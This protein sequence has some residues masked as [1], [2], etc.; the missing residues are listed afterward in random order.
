M[1]LNV[2]DGRIYKAAKDIICFK[3]FKVDEVSGELISPIVPMVYELEKTYRRMFFSGNSV[4]HYPRCFR[5]WL[6]SSVRSVERGF[7]S[8][9][10]LETAQ[11]QSQWFY[12]V[13][14]CQIPK[15]TRYILGNG[16]EYVSLKIKPLEIVRHPKKE[17]NE[18]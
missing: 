9:R 7:H 16:D 15:G 17:W 14:R 12:A 11:R 18:Q 3:K 13:V 5:F 8:Y 10:T 4:N 6:P 1:C 2:S